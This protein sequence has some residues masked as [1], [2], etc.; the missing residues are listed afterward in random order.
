VGDMIASTLVVAGAVLV[1]LAGIGVNR[2]GNVLA[3]MHAATKAATLGLLL[4]VAGAAI[5]VEDVSGT[6]KLLLVVALQL[7]TAPIAAHLVGRAAYRA[8][9]PSPGTT[10]DELAPVVEPGPRP[11]SDA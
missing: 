9:G 11:D 5:R 4:I 10:I 1:L 2:F 6:A 3:R 8:N 7:L